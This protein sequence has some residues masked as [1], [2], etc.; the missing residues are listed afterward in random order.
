MRPSEALGLQWKEVDLKR[1]TV[2]VRRT[3][4]R[5]KKMWHLAEPKTTKSRRTIPLPASMIHGAFF[6]AD[7][8]GLALVDAIALVTAKP[9]AMV[10]LDDRGAIAVGKRGDLVRIR[11]CHGTPA[12]VDVWRGGRKVA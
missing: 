9:A 6:L 5:L 12:V 3:L 8:L 7:E 4:V 11:V 2:T 1:G 10:G